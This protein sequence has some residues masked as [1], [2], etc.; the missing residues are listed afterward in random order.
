MLFIK[1]KEG[2]SVEEWIT[3]LH[4][5]QTEAVTAF[6]PDGGSMVSYANNRLAY[7]YFSS[8]AYSVMDSNLILLVNDHKDNIGVAKPDDNCEKISDFDKSILYAIVFNLKTGT[9]TRKK[10]YDNNE[11]S[12]VFMPR[13]SIIN[14]REF[15]IPAQ[16]I[17]I[18][19]LSEF[20]IAKLVVN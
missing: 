17:R 9:Y 6:G 2:N 18:F 13:F 20:K 4:K 3:G 19:K 16:N 15:Y 5:A 14:G 12:E 7:P 1:M 8:Y 11:N 10:I